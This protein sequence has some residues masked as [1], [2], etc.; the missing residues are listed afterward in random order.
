[1]TYKLSPG[2]PTPKK[3]PKNK[4]GW[5]A[6]PL[7]AGISGLLAL[8]A[9]P[10][11]I[12]AWWF[13]VNN[14]E[15]PPPPVTAIATPSPS[16]TTSPA[17]AI[18]ATVAEA[19]ASGPDCGG[20]AFLLT[21]GLDQLNAAP[22]PP[23]DDKPDIQGLNNWF[24]AHGATEVVNNASITIEGPHTNAAILTSIKPVIDRQVPAVGAV[25]GYWQCGGQMTLREFSADLAAPTPVVKGLAAEAAPGQSAAPPATFP[26]KV[27]ATDPEVFSIRLKRPPGDVTW[28]L[29]LQWTLDGVQGTTRVPA[30]GGFHSTDA[31]FYSD[32]RASEFL[33]HPRSYSN[34]SWVS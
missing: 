21:G 30:T 8:V 20:R 24:V 3:A 6:L 14:D 12:A 15:S 9:V 2:P 22:T 29:E 23:P 5:L 16:V 13:P 17:P 31:P 11:S 26:Y 33:K 19:N 28:H 25:V 10:I 7:W 27:S 18:I 4:S 32:Y 34:G 1:V